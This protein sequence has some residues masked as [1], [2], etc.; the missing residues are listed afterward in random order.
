[1]PE[2]KKEV[3]AVEKELRK[4]KAA[5]KEEKEKVM[6][7]KRDKKKAKKQKRK[8]GVENLKKQGRERCED[9]RIS[10]SGCWEEGWSLHGVG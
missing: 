7:E 2:V 5:R 4:Q 8:E 9:R 10:G 6:K 3:K 1:M